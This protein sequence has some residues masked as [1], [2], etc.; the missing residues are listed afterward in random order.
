MATLAE[1]SPHA[2]NDIRS[3][4]LSWNSFGGSFNVRR[5]VGSSSEI[6]KIGMKSRVFISVLILSGLS[7]IVSLLVL[8]LMSSIELRLSPLVLALLSCFSI[9]LAG[10]VT[11]LVSK[12]FVEPLQKLTDTSYRL[13]EREHVVL[14][15]DTARADEI[16]DLA[17]G[18]Q[19]LNTAMQGENESRMQ[20][21]ADTSH[22][23]RTPIAILRAQIEALQD[24][25]Q[26][27]TGR[28]LGVLHSEVMALSRLVDQLFELSRAD[29]GSLSYRF[30]SFDP[31]EIV[32]DTVESFESRYAEKEIRISTEFS[33]D[34]VFRIRADGDRIKQLF[35]NLFENSLRYT[36][37]GGETRVSAEQVGGRVIVR[38]DDSAPAVPAELHE[39]LFDRFFRVDS[40]RSREL[41]GTGL[42]LAICRN[43]VEAHD[44]EIRALASPLGGL[45]VEVDLPLHRKTNKSKV[46][47]HDK[48][49]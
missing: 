25:V 21:V 42:G 20:W 48:G 14:P 12:N 39:K 32:S 5:A 24:G 16:G 19:R 11:Y 44:G 2:D 35:V 36:D 22:E 1:W 15:L 49:S 8:S 6:L 31:L 18:L 46:I 30:G 33:K 43:I 34:Q 38:I 4:L 40:S 28:T 7:M 23:L 27:V 9:G 26:E 3:R 17:R 13:I 45:R 37:S 10:C 29:I 41:G 47:E